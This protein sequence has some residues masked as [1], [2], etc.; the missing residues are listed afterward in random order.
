VTAELVARQTPVGE[1]VAQRPRPGLALVP[2]DGQ[3]ERGGPRLGA[4]A[5]V[6]DQRGAAPGRDLPD[7][8]AEQRDDERSRRH[9]RR[10][11]QLPGA[12]ELEPTDC[13]LRPRSLLF[14]KLRSKPTA[15]ATSGS[16]GDH[17]TG[18]PPP[19]IASASDHVRPPST[20]R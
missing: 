19:L 18:P 17:A 14:R 7:E 8:Q 16:L 12:H 2:D 4:G 10:D 3:V 9:L 20:E 1:P 11:A 6:G 5:H 13:Q 15:Y